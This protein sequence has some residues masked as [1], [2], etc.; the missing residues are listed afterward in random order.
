MIALGPQYNKVLLR[1]QKA[2]NAS[3]G[4]LATV[5]IFK[6]SLRGLAPTKKPLKG[7]MTFFLF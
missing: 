1:E 7:V 2:K 3:N 4:T 6:N 5:A